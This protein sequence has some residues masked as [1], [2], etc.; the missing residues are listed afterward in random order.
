[1]HFMQYTYLLFLV[2]NC[3]YYALF[4]YVVTLYNKVH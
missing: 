4:I 3:M 2:L 1:M